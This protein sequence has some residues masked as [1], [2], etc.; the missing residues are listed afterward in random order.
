LTSPFPRL[1]IVLHQPEIPGNTGAVG[2]TCVGINAKLWLVRPLGFRVDEKSLRRAGLDYWQHL[3]WEVAD[4]WGDLVDRIGDTR[5]WFFSRFATR[6]YAEVEY[7]T[8]DTLVFGSETSGLP[9]K[10]TTGN[11]DHLLRIPTTQN[12][13]SLN[14]ATSVGV[15]AFEAVRQL[16]AG[17]LET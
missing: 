17:D 3:D 5:I 12:I 11:A 14:L 4:H 1:N 8:G 10:L 2:R 6:S 13:R 15:A 9:E 7:Q 16:S